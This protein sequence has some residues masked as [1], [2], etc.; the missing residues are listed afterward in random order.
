VQSQTWRYYH[1]YLLSPHEELTITVTRK[2]GDPDLYVAHGG[3]Y[4]NLTSWDWSSTAFGQ[5]LITIRSP[6][7]G[8]SSSFVV[9]TIHTYLLSYDMLINISHM[10]GE[11][12][13][14]VYGWSTASYIIVAST[15]ESILTLIDG[16]PFR[17]DLQAGNPSLPS[18]KCCLSGNVLLSS[19]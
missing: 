18:M 14:G 8:I 9:H 10:A 1:F 13:I 16:V 7:R 2:S 11:F 3:K 4:P 6:P 15:G 12:I 19:P 5:D 17:E